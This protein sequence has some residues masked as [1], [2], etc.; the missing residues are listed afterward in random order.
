MNLLWWRGKPSATDAQVVA[1][2]RC[3]KVTEIGAPVLPH[4]LAGCLR[5][6]PSGERGLLALLRFRRL[7]SAVF[8]P[9]EA[10]SFDEGVLLA[11][12]HVCGTTARALHPTPGAVR[13]PVNLA[14]PGRRGGLGRPRI[15][16]PLGRW[17]SWMHADP[18]P[19]V[20]IHPSGV[21]QQQRAR[22]IPRRRPVAAAPQGRPPLPDGDVPG[23]AAREHRGD[24][25]AQLVNA[26][27]R[28]G[29]P[30]TF[31]RRASQ[32]ISVTRNLKPAGET[33]WCAR[34]RPGSCSAGRQS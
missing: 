2:G 12:A 5:R 15:L 31:G 34:P 10:E 18:H 21:A 27:T 11:I 8:G 20:R 13:H 29:P 1:D 19:L 32:S 14:Q 16:P 33:R 30:E 3:A 6:R 17:G 26:A 25:E 9:S 22:P 28:C 23:V 4:L 7:A 24:G